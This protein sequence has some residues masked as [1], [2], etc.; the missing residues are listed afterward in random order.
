MTTDKP[1]SR[2]PLP[3]NHSEDQQTAIYLQIDKLKALTHTLLQIEVAFDAASSGNRQCLFMVMEDLLEE[4]ERLV[5][6]MIDK[7]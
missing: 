3:S 5:E 7:G 4:L 1:I 2:L 6:A